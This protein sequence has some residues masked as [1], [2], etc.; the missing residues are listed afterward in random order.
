MDQHNQYL[1]VISIDALNSNDFH[2]IRN[3]PV[4]RSFITEGSYSNNMLSIYPSLT[5]PCHTSI[6]TGTYPNKHGIV[7]NRKC[8]PYRYKNPE[9]Y[10][11]EN[12]I[13]V[14]TV[15]DYAMKQ[16]YTC[17]SI[18]WPVMAGADITYNIPELWP[19]G[20]SCFITNYIKNSTKNLIIPTLKNIKLSCS[21]Q[22]TLDDTAENISKYLILK[23]QPNLLFIHFTQLDYMRHRLGMNTIEAKDLLDNFDKRLERL[24]NCTKKA[25]IYEKTTFIVLGDHGMNDY[26]KYICINSI[27]KQKRLLI[28]DKKNSIISYKAFANACGGSAQICMKNKYDK[29]L[30]EKIYNILLE[31]QSNPINGIKQVYTSEKVNRLYHLDNS[32]QFV[33]EA[34]NG[35]VFNNHICNKLIIPRTKLSKPHIADHGFLPTHPNMKTVFFA[36]GNRIKNTYIHKMNLVD[37]APTIAM[38]MNL[39]MKNIDGNCLK[40]CL[41]Y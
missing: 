25:G 16:N 11:Y 29:Y 19:I 14:P 6:I 2:Y 35:Y 34:E 24:I 18:L 39:P 28:T 23:K 38:I 5:Y 26:D 9:W 41:E 36:K 1:Y 21:A 8:Q 17:A 30:Y 31:L 13:Q 7:S 12:D 32:F 37:I 4:F 20:P 22:P 27:F 40:S 15:F 3:L 33:L 10:W